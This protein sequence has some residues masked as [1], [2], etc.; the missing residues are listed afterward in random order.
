M[1]LR[2]NSKAITRLQT[3][4]YVLYIEQDNTPIK[5]WSTVFDIKQ[6]IHI[7]VGMGKGDFL[8]GMAKQFP[9]INFIGIEKYDTVLALAVKKIETMKLS[10]L[11]VMCCD[12]EHLS[13]LFEHHSIQT[14]YLNFSDPWPKKRH[15]KRRL[16]YRSY[17]SI[18]ETILTR[19]APIIMKTDNRSLFEYSLVSMNQYHMN[20]HDVCL[21]LHHSDGYETNI[22]T[23]YEHK[24]SKKGHVIYRLEA[25]F[26]EDSHE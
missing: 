18:Y 7:E 15:V 24:F 10:N 9:M 8:I 6:P 17:L 1:R 12:A 21:D 4:P 22:M 16:T 13:D 3:S 23:E 5:D 25:S 14:L 20:F 11:K 26:K 2:R 19:Q